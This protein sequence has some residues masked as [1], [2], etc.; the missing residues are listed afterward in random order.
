M[1]SFGDIKVKYR[2][3]CAKKKFSAWR[4]K[5]TIG[6]VWDVKE[7]GFWHD[8]YGNATERTLTLIN[9]QSSFYD[10]LSSSIG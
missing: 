5:M 9:K 6:I 3:I 1:A 4:K 8:S 7:K 10:N 2:I